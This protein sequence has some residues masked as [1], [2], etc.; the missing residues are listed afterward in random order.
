[1]ASG[2]PQLALTYT[3]GAYRQRPCPFIF[4]FPFPPPSHVPRYQGL[5]SI[6]LYRTINSSSWLY[7]NKI[8]KFCYSPVRLFASVDPCNKP[9]DPLQF[10]R[11]S[12][13]CGPTIC[14]AVVYRDPT[15][16]PYA[17]RH[18][19]GPSGSLCNIPGS[20]RYPYVTRL[21][22]HPA[23]KIQLEQGIPL[24]LELYRKWQTF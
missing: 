17:I 18:G 20:C 1:M 24:F 7:G 2:G 6:L 5:I 13:E 16:C 19:I 21:P 22:H 14:L 12:T 8:P 4:R 3:I 9:F 10:L 15:C 11:P 23:P